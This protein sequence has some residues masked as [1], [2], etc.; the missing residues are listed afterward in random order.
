MTESLDKPKFFFLELGF[1]IF[2][3]KNL[4]QLQYNEIQISRKI[5]T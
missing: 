1:K 4:Q 2:K 3:L 5:L